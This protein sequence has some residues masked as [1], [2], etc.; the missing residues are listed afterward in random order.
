MAFVPAASE[1]LTIISRD[2]CF[3]HLAPTFPPA[4][5]YTQ[6]HLLEQLFIGFIHPQD[7][8]TTRAAL[9]KLAQGEP[10]I[11]LENRFRCKDGSYRRLAWTAL[12]TPEGLL[13]A[14]ARDITERPQPE[15]DRARSLAREQTTALSQQE[16]FLTSVCH[17]LQQPLTVILAQTQMLL[18]ELARDQPLPPQA[19]ATRLAQIFAAA[20]RMRGMTQD[21]IDA[22]LQH[23]GRPLALLLA[24]TELVALTRQAVL[25]QQ[26]LSDLHHFVFEA[27]A[28][29][30]VVAVDEHRAHRVLAKRPTTFEPRW[31]QS[32][33]WG[34]S[35][36]GMPTPSS[37]TMSWADLPVSLSVISWWS[38]TAVP[39]R[40]RVRKARAAHSSC[41]CRLQHARSDAH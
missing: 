7:R 3:K 17:D 19:L 24:R 18:R 16:E 8:P 40:W 6:E 1:L 10:T 11:G 4:F 33:T 32:N 36:C 25:E 23:S 37:R 38:S 41:A 34:K 5:G 9:E 12:P 31:N 29:S 39:S 28:P 26:L 14:V 15:E 2:G 35:S 13:Y 27:E 21:L 20:T 30:L 22:A